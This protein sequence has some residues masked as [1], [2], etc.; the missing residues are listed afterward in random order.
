MIMLTKKIHLYKYEHKL[1]YLS[2]IG[3][4]FWGLHNDRIDSILNGTCLTFC[5]SDNL[6]NSDKSAHTHEECTKRIVQS[7]S[8]NLQKII[9]M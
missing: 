9:N 5:T 1:S 2:R 6:I 8:H 4:G 7:K 3:N